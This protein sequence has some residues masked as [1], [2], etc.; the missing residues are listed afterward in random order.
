MDARALE[1]LPPAQR[2]DDHCDRHHPESR[3]EPAPVPVA[4]RSGHLADIRIDENDYE[5]RGRDEDASCPSA[6]PTHASDHG[7]ML[8][9]GQPAPHL[10]HDRNPPASAC[11]RAT[12]RHHRAGPRLARPSAH[13]GVRERDRRRA[14]GSRADGHGAHAQPRRQAPRQPGRACSCGT[15]SGAR[16]QRWACARTGRPPSATTTSPRASFS[17]TSTRDSPTSATGVERRWRGS[18][19][20]PTRSSPTRASMPP[21][22]ARQGSVKRRLSRFS[23]SCR[24]RCRAV[25]RIA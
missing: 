2:A 24:P 23:W 7:G 6:M 14:R 9:T 12:R 1:Q 4:D 18:A 3:D 10:T 19:A 21:S 16:R 20:G 11:S 22:C 17:A 15:R 8:L 5:Q 25:S 13:L